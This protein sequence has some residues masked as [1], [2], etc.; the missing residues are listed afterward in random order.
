MEQNNFGVERGVRSGCG[1]LKG[2]KIFFREV[3]SLSEHLDVRALLE[4][5]RSLARGQGCR[6]SVGKEVRIDRTRSAAIR[7]RNGFAARLSFEPTTL[8]VV[9][10]SVHDH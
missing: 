8:V 9:C 10:T 3:V 2:K 6:R 4:S 7:D 1:Q 5:Y